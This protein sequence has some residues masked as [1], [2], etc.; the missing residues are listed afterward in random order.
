MLWLRS[1]FSVFQRLALRR[2]RVLPARPIEDQVCISVAVG[3]LFCLVRMSAS[4]KGGELTWVVRFVVA[5]LERQGTRCA[6]FRGAELRPTSDVR[7]N[8]QR[9]GRLSSLHA[10]VPQGLVGMTHSRCTWILGYAQVVWVTT[11]SVTGK[12]AGQF[13]TGRPFRRSQQFRRRFYGISTQRR[14]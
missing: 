8:S 2:R 4:G 1:P 12:N 13:L 14:S 10:P 11:W 3:G 5:S 7:L 9:M 6:S